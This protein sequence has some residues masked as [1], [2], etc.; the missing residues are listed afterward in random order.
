MIRNIIFDIEKSI[1]IDDT[2]RNIIS[3]NDIE[4]NGILFNNIEDIK[5]IL[6]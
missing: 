5:K 4:L 1:L 6:K 2:K 3:A